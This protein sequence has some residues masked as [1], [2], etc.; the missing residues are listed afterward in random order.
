M[1][2]FA[3][4]KSYDDA[5]WRLLH[6]AIYHNAP[7][8]VVLRLLELFPDAAEIKVD[9]DDEAALY[10]A[11]REESIS[12]EVV[13]ALLNIWLD[14]VAYVPNGDEFTPIKIACNNENTTVE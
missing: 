3:E 1:W 7:I 10:M 6:L 13:S 5:D 9:I 12:L 14:A 11:C 8:D 4:E 2:P